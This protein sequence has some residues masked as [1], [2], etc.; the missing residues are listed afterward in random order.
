MSKA[1]VAIVG[2]GPSGLTL[3]WWLVEHG[4]NVTVLEREGSIP[5]D[6][7]A[8]TFHPATLDLLMDSGLADALV[9]RGTVVPQ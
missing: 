6:M 3:A 9:K 5:R 2:A 7:R 4:V 1:T 8:S